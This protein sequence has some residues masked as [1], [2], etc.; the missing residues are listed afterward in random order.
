MGWRRGQPPR[1]DVVVKLTKHKIND[2]QAKAEHKPT[3]EYKHTTFQ[4]PTAA[5]RV[6][7]KIL[8]GP[9]HKIPKACSP[10]P[11]HTLLKLKLIFLKIFKLVHPESNKIQICAF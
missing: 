8:V 2:Q 9:I 1:S 3:A 5:E 6:A 7:N 4:Q 10:C 11:V